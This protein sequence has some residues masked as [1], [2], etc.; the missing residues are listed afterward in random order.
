MP[1]T[2]TLNTVYPDVIALRLGYYVSE[3]TRILDGYIGIMRLGGG[4]EA[5][6]I[7]NA[8]DW[9]TDMSAP[10]VLGLEVVLEPAYALSYIDFASGGLIENPATRITLKQWDITKTTVIEASLLVRKFA[11]IDRL[12]VVRVPRYRENGIID[13]TSMVI[14]D[15]LESFN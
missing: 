7:R 5:I 1:I 15:Y 11:L 10:E 14:L 6:A 4:A 8:D 2:S 13:Q 3:I 12:S 9:T